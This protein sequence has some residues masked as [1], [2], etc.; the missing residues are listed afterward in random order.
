VKFVFIDTDRGNLQNSHYKTFLAIE[1]DEMFYAN[2]I[3]K[4]KIIISINQHWIQYAYANETK[5]CQ[6]YVK[7]S[8]EL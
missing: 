8:E 3:K 4:N 7:D 2:T 1:V 6:V 5:K